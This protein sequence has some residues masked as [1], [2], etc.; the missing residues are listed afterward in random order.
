MLAI[1]KKYQKQLL[2]LCVIAALLALPLIWLPDYMSLLSFYIAVWMMGCIAAY[3]KLLAARMQE[4]YALKQENKWFVGGVRTVHIDTEVSREKDKMPVSAFWFLPA[5]LLASA[6]PLYLWL[7]KNTVFRC[8]P[9]CSP[10]FSLQSGC[11]CIGSICRAPQR[12]SVN[13]LR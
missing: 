1:V 11:L 8:G 5:F 12:Y 4:L 13:P 2:L 6:A 9:P 7:S 3:T 10:S